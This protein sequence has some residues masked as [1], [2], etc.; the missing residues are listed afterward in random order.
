MPDPTVLL[1]VPE[2]AAWAAKLPALCAIQSLK[3]RPVEQ[4][5]LDRPLSALAQGLR[6]SEALSD[7][8]PLPEPLL[9]FCHFSE[10]QLNRFLQ[11]LR[12][13]EVSCLKAV[14]TPSNAGWTLRALYG[15]LCQERLRLGDFH[16]PKS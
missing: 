5:D 12:R 2:P 13:L 3:F 8:V 15:E 1:Y 11:S 7:P 6:P 4:N 9:I 16:P 14:L 10:K